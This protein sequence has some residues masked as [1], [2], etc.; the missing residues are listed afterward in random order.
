MKYR[1][2]RVL[3]SPREIAPIP[4][5]LRGFQIAPEVHRGLRYPIESARLEP[6][7]QGA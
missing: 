5:M 4:E 1:A 3:N 6:L 2:A 7:L